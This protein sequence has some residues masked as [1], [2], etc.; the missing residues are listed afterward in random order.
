MFARTVGN[1]CYLNS[2]I[3]CLSHIAPLTSY[4][5]SDDYMKAMFPPELEGI[6]IDKNSTRGMMKR[7]HEF[8]LAFK[9]LLQQ[10]WLQHII[11]P[12]VIEGGS[13]DARGIHLQH[14]HMPVSA[15]AV[16]QQLGRINEDYAGLQQ[17]DTHDVLETILD[18]LHE[19]FNII[20]DKPYVL[21]VEGTGVLCNVVQLWVDLC[22]CFSPP[23]HLSFHLLLLA[24]WIGVTD[25]EDGCEA[26][27]RHLLRDNSVIDD[28]LGTSTMP[29]CCCTCSVM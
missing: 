24:Y 19:D 16:K 23:I 11:P 20:R 28:L 7:S 4:F 14:Q 5:L 25:V 29:S 21:N 12:P 6:V 15:G 27:R 3:Q 22:E 2:G 10:L 17:Q 9:S 8:C 26:H 18:Q 1:S 13:G